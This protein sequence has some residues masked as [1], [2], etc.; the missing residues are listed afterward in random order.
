MHVIQDPISIDVIDDE[1]VDNNYVHIGEY[2][3]WDDVCIALEQKSL[4]TA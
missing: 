2:L 1:Y 4:F 3:N